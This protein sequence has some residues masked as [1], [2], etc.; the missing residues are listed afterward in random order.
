M[1]QQLR[2]LGYSKNIELPILQN[3]LTKLRFSDSVLLLD[4]VLV[5]G[6]AVIAYIEKSPDSRDILPY[7]EHLKC[8]LTLA[9]Y[10]NEQYNNRYSLGI[11]M[12]GF[13][14]N[15]LF[16]TPKLISIRNS[17]IEIPA[18]STF[19]IPPAGYAMVFTVFYDLYDPKKHRV[20]NWG[21]L[22]NDD[23]E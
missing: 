1:A 16:F 5:H 23:E 12:Q 18:I 4:K 3:T 14:P 17:F 9:G 20:N 2:R 6:L 15:L 7:A 13:F 8:Y 22:L 10:K 21:E 11:F 19:V